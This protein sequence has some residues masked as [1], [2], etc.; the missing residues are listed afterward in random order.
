MAASRVM[1]D[2]DVVEELCQVMTGRMQDVLTELA[3]GVPP[4]ELVMKGGC[5]PSE[6]EELL[7]DLSARG[8]VTAVLDHDKNELLG[9]AIDSALAATGR[10][11]AGLL[12]SAST[13]VREEQS[14]TEV[15]APT[16]ERAGGAASLE[17]AVM[18]EVSQ[19]S[20]VPVAEIAERGARHDHPSECG[21]EA[22]PADR[23]ALAREA[24]TEEASESVRLDSLA[25]AAIDHTP[26]PT[27]LDDEGVSSV[28]PPQRARWRVAAAFLGTA[29]LALAA[30][31]GTSAGRAAAASEVRPPAPEAQSLVVSEEPAL[32]MPAEAPSDVAPAAPSG[33]PAGAQ[34]RRGATAPRGDR[35]GSAARAPSVASPGARSGDPRATRTGRTNHCLAP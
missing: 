18:L 30:S 34:D 16:A 27:A 28:R 19:R 13:L 35:P 26:A 21:V 24:Q 20:P 2:A 7:A 31:R 25:V 4:C 33:E 3:V 10:A 14:D 17:A 32:D 11:G 1:L 6:L 8:A 12:P 23:A 9:A 29:A 5:A 22:G 15:S